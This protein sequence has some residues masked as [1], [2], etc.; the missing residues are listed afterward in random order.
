VNENKN[1][2]SVEVTVLLP[3]FNEEQAIAD[4][5]QRIKELHPDFEVLVVD[6][7]S[8]DNTMRAAMKV[9]A[10]RLAASI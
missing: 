5:V 10:R 7:G 3:A 4:T 9:G 6:D 2:Q 8:T 1:K